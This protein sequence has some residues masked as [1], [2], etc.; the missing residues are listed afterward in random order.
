M[1][2]TAFVLKKVAGELLNPLSIG[3]FIALCGLTALQLERLRAAKGLLALAFLWIAAVSY[4]PFGDAIAKPLERQFPAL[5]E[6]PVGIDYILVLGSGHA[7]DAAV[8][9]TA[10]LGSTA[11]ARLSEGIRHYNRLGDAKLVVSGY[12]GPHDPNSH[13]AMER[14]AAIALGIAAEDIVMLEEARDTAEEALA[15]KQIAGTKPFI[16]VTSATHM[17]RAYAIFRANGLNPVAAPTD[18]YAVGGSEW[19]QMPDSDGLK[20]SERAFHEYLGQLWERI[21]RW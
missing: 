11:L 19:L 12:S 18:Y 17:P 6:T 7:T 13:A 9:I 20:E 4:G 14:K 10:Q 15:M 5:I 3:L 16:L 1:M 21:K 2:D 8:P